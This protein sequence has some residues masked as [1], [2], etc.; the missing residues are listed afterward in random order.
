[1]WVPHYEI[2]RKGGEE[3]KRFSVKGKVGSV[4]GGI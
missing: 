1:M 2:L 3:R 4:P